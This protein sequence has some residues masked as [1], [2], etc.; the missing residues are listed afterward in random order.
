MFQYKILAK[1]L[2][3]HRIILEVCQDPVINSEKMTRTPFDL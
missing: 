3:F 1:F 2:S